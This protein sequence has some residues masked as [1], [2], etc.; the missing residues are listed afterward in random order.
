MKFKAGWISETLDKVGVEAKMSKILIIEND[1]KTASL[2]ADALRSG[3]NDVSVYICLSAADG[4]KNLKRKSFDLVITA[5]RLADMTGFELL[6]GMAE[7]GGHWPTII[8]S[9]PGRGDE[10]VKYMRIGVY[11]YIVKDADFPHTLPKAAQR[12]LDLSYVFNEKRNIVE[13]SIEREWRR[14]L[15]RMAHILNHEVNDPLMAIIGNVQLLLSRTEI[16]SGELREKLEAIEDSARRIAR[17]MAFFADRDIETHNDLQDN[18]PDRDSV[19][20]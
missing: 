10:A 14:G 5:S 12:A 8:L 13:T 20:T 3:L 16:K 4:M 1:K 9:A 19:L 2:A 7:I 18:A 11:D 6:K 17:V 15:S